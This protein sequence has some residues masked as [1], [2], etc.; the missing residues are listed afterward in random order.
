MSLG[1]TIVQGR[2]K[3]EGRRDGGAAQGRRG[4]SRLGGP[5][6]DIQ[7]EEEGGSALCWRAASA[8]PFVGQR[9]LR[10][11]RRGAQVP[12]QDQGAEGGRAA[13]EGRGGAEEEGGGGRREEGRA[14]AGRGGG[15]AEG[16]GQ[17]NHPQPHRR[18]DGPDQ[19]QARGGGRSG[20]RHRS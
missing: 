17:G 5:K 9:R 1:L 6:E 3:E 15:P 10:P 20:E 19:Q 14:S 13:E 16:G 8:S 11:A 2:E 12:A 18:A 7:A 4:G